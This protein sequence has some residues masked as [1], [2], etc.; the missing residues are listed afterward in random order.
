[1]PAAAY[2]VHSKKEV[3]EGER[4]PS[5]PDEMVGFKD[6]EMQA[7]AENEQTNTQALEAT[8]ESATEQQPISDDITA[9][10]P[11]NKPRSNTVRREADLSSLLNTSEKAE[12][13]ALVTRVTESMLKHVTLLFDPVPDGTKVETSRN[14]VW[15]KLPNHLKDLSLHNPM[16][17]TQ[18]RL[19]QK[20]NIKPPRS[21][22]AGRTRDKRGTAPSAADAPS[23]AE[24]E[25]T[26]R[27]Q[28]L[29]KE[30][31]IHFKKWQTAV[32][33]RVG[34]ISVKKGPDFQPSPASIG[35]RKRPLSNKRG[36]AT[37]RILAVRYPAS[38]L[39]TA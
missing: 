9:E 20:E 33:R 2:L 1:V 21:K 14:T 16:N 39:L 3:T 13:T 30:A 10:M 26:P 25:A 5:V 6:A 27:L 24:S 35:P 4:V 34:E 37:G 19:G 18:T 12:L 31:L 8:S 15:S 29:K 22:K 28:E 11:P 23:R 36:K 17:E 32:H 7:T 38:S